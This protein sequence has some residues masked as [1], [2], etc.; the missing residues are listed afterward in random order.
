MENAQGLY[1]I[2]YYV[3]YRYFVYVHYKK[4]IICYCNKP[5]QLYSIVKSFSYETRYTIRHKTDLF[6]RNL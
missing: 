5:F 1:A 6:I 2:N 4:Y 3:I